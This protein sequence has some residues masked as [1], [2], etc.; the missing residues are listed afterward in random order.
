VVSQKGGTIRVTRDRSNVTI[1]GDG[2]VGI[3]TPRAEAPDRPRD[4]QGQNEETP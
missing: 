4:K 3:T 1:D 2:A